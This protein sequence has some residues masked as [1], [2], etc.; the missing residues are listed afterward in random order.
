MSYNFT[1]LIGQAFLVSFGVR[2]AYEKKQSI[3]NLKLYRLKN[4]SSLTVVSYVAARSIALMA[5]LNI[6]FLM[7]YNSNYLNQLISNQLS[8]DIAMGCLTAIT[9]LPIAYII[10]PFIAK[11]CTHFTLAKPISLNDVMYIEGFNT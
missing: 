7:G 2:E 8:G 6:G 1:S 9:S 3:D 4:I 10:A 5:I 11:G